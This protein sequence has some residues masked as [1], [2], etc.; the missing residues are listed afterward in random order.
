MLSDKENPLPSILLDTIAM[1]EFY[2]GCTP[3]LPSQNMQDQKERAVM[4]KIVA[5]G[6]II[7]TF[8]ILVSCVTDS[9][10]I[11]P[12]S[13]VSLSPDQQAIRNLLEKRMQAINTAD[14]DLFDS[15]YVYAAGV[16]DVDKFLR[17]AEKNLKKGLT[18]C[19]L[20]VKETEVAGDDALVTFS[21]KR[22]TGSSKRY[23][24][25][26]ILQ[27]QGGEWKFH[28]TRWKK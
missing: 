6:L 5:A 15:I 23:W 4:K 25:E 19:C 28:L 12:L 16:E 18:Q 11:A 26:A 27:K 2:I 13:Q 8:G 7:F 10:N 24:A 14:F 20:Q 22:I 17:N 1:L 9:K 3:P 21:V